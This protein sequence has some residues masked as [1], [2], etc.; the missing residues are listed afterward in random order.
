[1]NVVAGVG[2]AA[3]TMTRTRRFME[4]VNQG[5]FA[6]RGLKASIYKDKQLVERLPHIRDVPVLA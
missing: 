3:V 5:Y 2:T 6:P 1:M 4:M